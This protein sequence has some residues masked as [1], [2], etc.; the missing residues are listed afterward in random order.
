MRRII[1]AAILASVVP[2][3]VTHDWAAA[4]DWSL[5]IATLIGKCAIVLLLW[6]LV[7]GWKA[8][9][10]RLTDD[11]LAVNRVHQ[12]VGI[13]GLSL[14]LA[15]PALVASTSDEP[16][17]FL[18]PRFT[19]EAEIWISLGRLALILILFVWLSS[20]VVRSRLTYRWWKRL[21][22]ANYAA[23]PLVL[24]HSAN[25]TSAPPEGWA[26]AY[27]VT[28]SAVFMALV[29]GRA[30]R[31]LGIG[32]RRCTVTRIEHVTR[33]TRSIVLAPRRPIEPLPGQFVYIQWPRLGESHPFTVS[34]FDHVSGE[35]TIT[36]KALG[37]FSR[38]LHGIAPGAQVFIDGPYGVFTR[39]AWSTGRPI[40]L[41]AGGI[42]ITPFLR[43]LETPP[44][45]N[46]KP[47]PVTLLYGN[48][49]HADIAFREDLSRLAAQNRSLKIVNVLSDE[50]PDETLYP[51]C[52]RGRIDAHVFERHLAASLGDYEYFVCGPPPM[53]NAVVRTLVSLGV[54]LER[55]HTERFSM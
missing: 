55:V 48:K 52:Q 49:T 10:R 30:L 11:W 7:L 5:A 36:P 29:A 54:P 47:V 12:W 34:H 35:L 23:V 37:P 32:Q 15:H 51:G 46:G 6:Q 3:V 39:E 21:H 4:D 20:V 19:D 2:V 16:V 24:A 1:P 22:L 44:A 41:V 14:F 18:V 42:G 27:W 33:D 45:R 25:I 43:L 38:R 53:M 50:P 17:A 8:V 26:R 13:F 40:V 9:L 28:V 31:G